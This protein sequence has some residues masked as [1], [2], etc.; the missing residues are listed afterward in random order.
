MSDSENKIV[1]HHTK[2]TDILGHFLDKY[3]GT[4]IN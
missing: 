2:T 1:I 3:I 4:L